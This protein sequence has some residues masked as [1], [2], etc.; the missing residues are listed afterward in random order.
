MGEGPGD[1]GEPLGPGLL[2]VLS[3]RH[4]HPLSSSRVAL[5]VSAS[6][7]FFFAAAPVVQAIM[8]ILGVGIFT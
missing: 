5:L 1:V 6:A 8:T 7:I 2:V 3:W 4:P